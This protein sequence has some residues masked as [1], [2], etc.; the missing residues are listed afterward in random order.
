MSK[1]CEKI[2][3]ALLELERQRA[4]GQKLTPDAVLKMLKKAAL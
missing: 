4:Q 3:E 2:R 1:P